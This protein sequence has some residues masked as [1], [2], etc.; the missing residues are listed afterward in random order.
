[1]RSAAFWQ[2]G[3]DECDGAVLNFERWDVKGIRG[4]RESRVEGAVGSCEFSF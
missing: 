4:V 3:F 1:M 2:V